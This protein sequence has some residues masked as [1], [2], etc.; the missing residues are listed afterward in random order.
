VLLLSS[1]TKR[2]LAIVGQGYVGLQI[3]FAF[4]RRYPWT[5]DFFIG[6]KQ[7]EALRAGRDWTNE[8]RSVG[9]SV[10]SRMCYWSLRCI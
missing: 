10:R 3:A 6:A 8:V 2:K 7:V 5:M 1:E 4:A 9:I